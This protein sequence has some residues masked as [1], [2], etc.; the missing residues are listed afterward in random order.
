MLKIVRRVKKAD[1]KAHFSSGQRFFTP[2]ITLSVSVKA[3][4]TEPSAWT[5]IVGAKAIPLATG[6]NLL[7][8]RARAI[9]SKRA[10]EIGPGKLLFFNFKKAAAPLSY[11]ALEKDLLE[12]LKKAK[13]LQP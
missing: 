6:R 4:K 11:P 1:F 10:P 3:D 2:S 12:L 5:F 8:R 9:I 7:K 13:I